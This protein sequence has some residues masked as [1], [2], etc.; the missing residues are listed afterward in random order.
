MIRAFPRP[1][2]PP[3]LAAFMLC[4][5]GPWAQASAA[6]AA[7]A[8]VGER[9]GP[10]AARAAER[11]AP[12]LRIEG[13][14][15]TDAGELTRA[16]QAAL[17]EDAGPGAIEALARVIEA[18]VRQAGRPFARA[19][20]PAGG[21]MGGIVRVVVVEG[22]YGR[23]DLRGGAAGDAAQ[24]FDALQPGRPIG[25]E[26]ARQV[27]AVSRL[28][29]V[30]V[31]AGLGP[32]DEAGE[33]DVDVT[34]EQAR[35]W[36]LDLR[37]DN[38]GNP[39]AGRWRG[40]AAG[41]VNGLLRFGDRL[42]ASAGGNNGR[43]WEGAASY[44]T[45][46]GR[47]GARA[48]LSASRHHYQLGG[49]F[50]RLGAQGQVEA[51][52]VTVTVPLTTRAPA[53]LTW[54]IGAEARRITNRQTAVGLSDR[55]RALA[56]TTGLQTVLFPSAGTVAWGGLWMEMGHVRLKDASAAAFDAKT[57]RAAGEYLVLSADA[58]L[59][60]QWDAWGLLLRG[61]GQMSD[62]NLDASRKFS[63]GGARSVRAWPLGE[64]SGD[65]G[66]LAQTELRY[67]WRGLE[68][69]AF[70][71]IGRVRFNHTPWETGLQG[72]RAKAAPTG[73]TLAGAGLGLRWQRGHWSAEGT[74]G[75]RLGSAAQRVS[76]SDPKG[77][78]PQLWISVAY[79][80]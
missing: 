43:G 76:T 16:G 60:R 50:E 78:Q 18:K 46:L 79:S 29:G 7:D 9:P 80:L 48:A 17:D 61:S 70:A 23:V 1:M 49:E 12:R 31:T 66:A 55:R 39:Y 59:L 75:W 57:V 72:A 10:Q 53:R 13:V 34:V 2:S 67:R 56:V 51:G 22:R 6:P 14:T 30:T 32:G 65:D 37:A 41:H 44:Q 47:R 71:D 64:A 54:Q 42:T 24:W 4:A 58:A 15:V 38:H 25:D 68:P 73:R 21:A 77:R 20:V 69:F 19:Y 35:R 40:S 3:A 8:Q 36:A 45:P 26:L 62:K 63:I 27:E 5:A 33:G 74:A 52:G 28:P 11:V